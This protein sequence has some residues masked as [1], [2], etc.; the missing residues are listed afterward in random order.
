[1]PIFVDLFLE[2]DLPDPE[3]ARRV[4]PREEIRSPATTFETPE[5]EKE[6]LV[7]LAKR[8]DAMLATN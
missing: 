6:K 8:G 3:V 2:I 7:A 4:F 1:M 5:K